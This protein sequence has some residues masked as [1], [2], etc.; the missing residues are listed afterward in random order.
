MNF[1]RIPA[2]RLFNATFVHHSCS[3]GGSLLLISF[4]PTE[5]EG[6]TEMRKNHSA[7]QR[8]GILAAGISAAAIAAA[9]NPRDEAAST[10]PAGE[11]E[12]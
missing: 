8:L 12:G 6:E 3:S 7:G 2:G 10:A 4:R 9:P 5:H 11:Y 1:R